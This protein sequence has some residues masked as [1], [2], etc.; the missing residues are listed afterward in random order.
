MDP[1]KYEWTS[2]QT[3]MPTNTCVIDAQIEQLGELLNTIKNYENPYKYISVFDTE[4]NKLICAEITPNL[5]TSTDEIIQ[6]E[7]KLVPSKSNLQQAILSK[8]NE[9]DH[10][11]K[12]KLTR[13]IPIAMKIK[14]LYAERL[15]YDR[16]YYLVIFPSK[17]A[18]KFKECGFNNFYD[19][20][21][22]Q[23]ID[24]IDALISQK[25]KLL[26]NV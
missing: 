2:N 18:S 13:D 24:E 1:C 22:H 19:S 3:N 7:M 12:Y 25:I 14:I 8:Y 15:E 23:L 16:K 6:R 5:F 21:K 4:N 26:S 10:T 20:V 9:L 11:K 17:Y